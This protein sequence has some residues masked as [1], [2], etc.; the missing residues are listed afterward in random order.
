MIMQNRYRA[1]LFSEL[2]HP[3]GKEKSAL[4]FTG[5]KTNNMEIKAP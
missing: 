4:E 3:D 1:K 5:A 2:F